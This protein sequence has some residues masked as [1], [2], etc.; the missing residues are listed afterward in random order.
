M[1][2]TLSAGLMVIC[3]VGL[4]ACGMSDE[5]AAALS[6]AVVIDMEVAETQR[7]VEK[8]RDFDRIAQETV[9]GMDTSGLEALGQ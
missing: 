3:V 2:K 4:A 8:S 1:S 6:D 9:A 5:E 7:E